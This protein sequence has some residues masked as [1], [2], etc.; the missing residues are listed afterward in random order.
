MSITLYKGTVSRDFFPPVFTNLSEAPLKGYLAPADRDPDHFQRIQNGD[1]ST[2]VKILYAD[3]RLN[4]IACA[5]L[6][7]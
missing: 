2:E 7:E 1:S 4:F 6:I 5:S 3:G